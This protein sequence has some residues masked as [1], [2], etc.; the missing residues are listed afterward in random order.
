MPKQMKILVD[1]PALDRLI[2]YLESNHQ[3][4]NDAATDQVGQLTQSLK[5]SQSRL[6]QAVTQQKGNE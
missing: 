6:Q 2:T 4:E 5:Q 1:F 3:K